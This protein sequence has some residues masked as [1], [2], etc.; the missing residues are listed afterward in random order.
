MVV[1]TLDLDPALVNDNKRPR[2]KTAG[3]LWQA[4][5]PKCRIQLVVVAAKMLFCS[6]RGRQWINSGVRCQYALPLAT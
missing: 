1:T 5:E 2:G 4:T 3:S 6:L